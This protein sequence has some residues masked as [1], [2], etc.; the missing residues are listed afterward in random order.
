VA[1]TRRVDDGETVTSLTDEL[2]SIVRRY[3]ERCGVPAELDVADLN[4]VS[5]FDERQP[6]RD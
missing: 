4:R 6:A 5:L 2:S 1:G 3:D